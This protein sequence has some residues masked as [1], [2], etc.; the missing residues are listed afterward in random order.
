MIG[1]P[2]DPPG[3]CTTR[4]LL[5][6]ATQYTVSVWY[7]GCVPTNRKTRHRPLAQWEIGERKAMSGEALL[8]VQS[9]N[10]IKHLLSA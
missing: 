9:R 8:N 3:G 6:M 10:Y 2:R 5:E 7:P 1:Q 4:H